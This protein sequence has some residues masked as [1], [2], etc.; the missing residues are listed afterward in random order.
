MTRLLVGVDG[1][2][3]RLPVHA[4][5][6]MNSVDPRLTLLPSLPRGA[7]QH[8]LGAVDESMTHVV[9]DE[10]GEAAVVVG[11]GVVCGHGQAVWRH[12]RRI[13]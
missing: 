6:F 13:A 4:V 3:D 2:S 11:G 1:L 8:G 10:I 12:R 5:G 7:R 9:E